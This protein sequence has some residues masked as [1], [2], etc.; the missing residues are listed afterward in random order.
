[1]LEQARRAE[2][3]R[4]AAEAAAAASRD[5]ATPLYTRAS[6]HPLGGTS[7]SPGAAPAATPNSNPPA[8]APSPGVVARAAT[9]QGA[10]PQLE[11]TPPPLPYL[12]ASPSFRAAGRATASDSGIVAASPTPG[13]PRKGGAAPTPLTVGSFMGRPIS[14][15]PLALTLPGPARAQSGP[16]K[17]PGAPAAA[18]AAPD[19]D[20]PLN[21]AAAS[22]MRPAR[23]SLSGAG[24]GF[25]VAPPSPGLARGAPPAAAAALSPS[26]RPGSVLGGA[27]SAF[28]P[29][30][31]HP[32][33]A[34]LRSGD[35]E[36]DRPNN[37]LLRRGA[38]SPALAAEG[39]PSPPARRLP[40][41]G[42]A[43]SSALG[44]RARHSSSGVPDGATAIT[45]AAAATSPFPSLGG[46]LNGGLLPWTSSMAA[47]AG[48]PG[49]PGTTTSVLRTSLHAPVPATLVASE[50]VGAYVQ[51]L[52]GASS[53]PS[54]PG[55]MGSAA[56]APLAPWPSGPL[57]AGAGGAAAKGPL[58]QRYRAVALSAD[59]PG[60]A[61]GSSVMPALS[62]GGRLGTAGGA[63]TFVPQGARSLSRRFLSS[64][65]GSAVSAGAAAAAL[66]AEGGA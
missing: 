14:P 51:F 48:S 3:A 1:M 57:A 47:Y 9:A 60:G 61:T 32:F 24:E 53:S 54:L 13:A 31:V 34:L 38:T 29:A 59:S 17:S 33:D 26:R 30:G 4:A 39:S 35:A 62:E 36:A 10:P 65:G 44:A 2:E 64:N 40:Q 45:S 50:R 63:G 43:L 42:R 20:S 41:V 46:S 52:H 11:P 23:T 55:P 7:S 16:L 27:A 22:R 12:A 18:A 21:P 28:A 15:S 37:A 8:R 66:A 49:R 6:P 56:A 58:G 19:G 5:A 25:A